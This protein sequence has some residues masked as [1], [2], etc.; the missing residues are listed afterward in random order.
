MTHQ[1][2]SQELRAAYGITEGLMRMNVGI[3]NA[4]DIIRDLEQALDK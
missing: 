1:G 2:I 3:E 4:D